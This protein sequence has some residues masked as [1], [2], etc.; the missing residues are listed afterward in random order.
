MLLSEEAL[1][2]NAA[3]YVGAFAEFLLQLRDLAEKAGGS[4]EKSEPELKGW[5]RILLEF[6]VR[7]NL[8]SKLKAISWPGEE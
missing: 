7:E 4:D 1:T 8:S 3:S 6:R 5:Y 2:A